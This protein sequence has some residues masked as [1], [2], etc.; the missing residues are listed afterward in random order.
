MSMKMLSFLLAMSFAMTSC[1]DG[2]KSPSDAFLIPKAQMA[3]V[4]KDANHGDLRAIK[5][6]IAHYEASSG[7][8]A[9][10]EW[11]AKARALGDAQ[12]LYYYAA[13]TFTGAR[14]EPD[15]VKKREMLVEALES[16]K[17][18]YASSADASTQQLIDEITRVIDSKQ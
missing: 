6:L 2:L 1:G 7:N 4:V 10:E 15:L 9:A 13:R 14:S 17:R 11:R 3:A 5:R 16:A 12:E 18:S 8:D